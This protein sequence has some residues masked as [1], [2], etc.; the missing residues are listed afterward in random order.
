VTL[1]CL[2]VSLLFSHAKH[3]LSRLADAQSDF[4]IDDQNA[5]SRI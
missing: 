3:C 4:T 2:T 1:L 5:I